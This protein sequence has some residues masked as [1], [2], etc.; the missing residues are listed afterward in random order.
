MMCCNIPDYLFP[1]LDGFID[2]YEIKL[3]THE[4]IV[5]DRNHKGS[6]AWSPEANKAIGQCINYL[7]EIEKHQLE[8]AD[9]IRK[10]YDI[11][12][13][14]I[15]PRAF[16]VIS[17]DKMLSDAKEREALR[18]LN[19]SLH[20]IEVITYSDLERRGKQML[21]IYGYK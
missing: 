5:P 9:G 6:F 13:S 19:Y 12:V 15:K 8:L 7:Y 18:K 10:E 14:F 2:M 4:V 16:V 21:K 1:T 20:G 11:E 3:P 17:S